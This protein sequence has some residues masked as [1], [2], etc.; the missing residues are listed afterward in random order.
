MSSMLPQEVRHSCFHDWRGLDGL[1]NF[2]K[3]VDHEVE[4]DR[5]HV[6]LPLHAESVGQSREAAH[7]SARAR[8]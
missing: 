7:P 3:V 4:A 8:R 6:V 1:V 5:V 2:Y